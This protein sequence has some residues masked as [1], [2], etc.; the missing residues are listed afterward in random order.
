[1]AIDSYSIDSL[2]RI[3]TVTDVDTS[4]RICRVY[5][6]D[7]GYTSG[8]LRVL[9]NTPSDTGYTSGGSDEYAFSSHAH[10]ISSWMPKVNDSVLV[11]YLPAQNSDGYVLGGI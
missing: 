10:G 8:W 4:Q 5:Y 3:G 11:L 6:K 9:I 1:M 7:R 2:V